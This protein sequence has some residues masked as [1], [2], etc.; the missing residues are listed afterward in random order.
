M[1]DLKKNGKI[2]WLMGPTS[3]GKSTLAKLLADSLKTTHETVIHFDGDEV[4]DYFG[5]NFGFEG[6][7]R[8]LVVKTIVKLAN[9]TSEAGMTT[10]VSALTAN[11]EARKYLY[12]KCKNLFL[13]YVKC[14]IEECS[15]RDPKGLYMKARLGEIDTLIGYNSCYKPPEHPDLVVNSEIEEPEI[16]VQKILSA[17]AAENG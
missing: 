10:I 13:I 6:A 9:K 15:R 16:C 14:S 3:S 11:D 17:V 7:N 12:E 1:F 8:F 4:R 2:I 5:E